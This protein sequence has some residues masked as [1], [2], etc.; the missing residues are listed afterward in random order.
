MIFCTSHLNQ[1][2]GFRKV[3]ARIHELL[4]VQIQVFEDKIYSFLTVDN[5]M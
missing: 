3:R 2:G 1:S 4:E 5:I